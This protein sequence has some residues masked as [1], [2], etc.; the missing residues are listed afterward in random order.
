M[1]DSQTVDAFGNTLSSGDSVQLTQEL[2][3]GGTKVT[4]KKWTKIK[5]IRLTDD[6]EEITANTPEVKWLVLKT[7]FVKKVD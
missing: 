7:Q 6:N 3:V 1:E 2:K 4:L 5:N